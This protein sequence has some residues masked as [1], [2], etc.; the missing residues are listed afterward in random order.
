MDDAGHV[1]GLDAMD[2]QLGDDDD[3]VAADAGLDDVG[4]SAGLDVA[5]LVP[6][7]VKRAPHT[8]L[9]VCGLSE[10]AFR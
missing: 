9:L 10:N 1:S 6:D 8:L 4:V 3:V 5:T 7:D 2:A